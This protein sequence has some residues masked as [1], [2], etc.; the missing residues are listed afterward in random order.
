MRLQGYLDSESRW[1]VSGPH[2]SNRCIS[3]LCSPFWSRNH[4]QNHL[5]ACC[6]QDGSHSSAYVGPWEV[7]S[8]LVLRY[9]I[10]SSAPGS[11]AGLH[12]AQGHM[13]RLLAQATREPVG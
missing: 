12:T 6:P 7:G 13:K 3:K 9:R 5:S 10:L 8:Q 1:V 4:S 2:C 11:A